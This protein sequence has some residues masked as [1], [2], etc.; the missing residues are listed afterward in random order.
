MCNTYYNIIYAE[1]GMIRFGTLI[2]FNFSICFFECILK[3][4]LDKQLPGPCRAIR[5]N[6]I[7][8]N[9]TLPPS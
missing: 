6:S 3:L 7:S 8:V 5:G 9:S 4:K 1:G 2:E